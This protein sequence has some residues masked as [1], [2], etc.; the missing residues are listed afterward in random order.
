MY[1]RNETI[2]FQIGSTWSDLGNLNIDI[3]SL[4]ISGKNKSKSQAPSMN[5]MSTPMSPTVPMSPFG[6]K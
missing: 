1:V 4:S 2:C 5:Q 3:E 6:G